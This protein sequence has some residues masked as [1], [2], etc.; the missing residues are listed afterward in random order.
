MKPGGRAAGGW[1]APES[2]ARSLPPGF[3]RSGICG[4]QRSRRRPGNRDPPPG[5]NRR[6][7]APCGYRG[8]GVPARGLTRSVD[9]RGMRVWARRACLHF[10][11]GW[12]LFP[13]P[14]PSIGGLEN[15]EQRISAQQELSGARPRCACSVP[16]LRQARGSAAASS[17]P[18]LMAAPETLG[19]PVLKGER[20]GVEPA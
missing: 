15:A 1:A 4:P 16:P 8:L 20:V 11:R 6:S 5:G 19:G 7:G 14:R 3:I 2:R 13:P 17:P 10:S 12:T 18:P 9:L